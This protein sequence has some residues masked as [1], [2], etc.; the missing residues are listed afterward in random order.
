MDER[1]KRINVMMIERRNDCRDD[2]SNDKKFFKKIQK[3][4]F[5]A[6]IMYL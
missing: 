6:L 3:T 2:S 4:C 5:K 1:R